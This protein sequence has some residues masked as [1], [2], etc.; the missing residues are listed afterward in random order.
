VPGISSKVVLNPGT[1]L[2]A[3][4]ALALMVPLVPDAGETGLPTPLSR[5]GTLRPNRG[6]V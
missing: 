3:W 1:A 2:P 6:D 4:A 5:R